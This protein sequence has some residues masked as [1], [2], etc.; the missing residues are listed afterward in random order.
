M[1]PDDDLVEVTGLLSVEPP[2][3]EVVND[4]G[5]GSREAADHLLGRV[6]GA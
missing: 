4:G 3:S 6:V 2:K 5:I 1:P